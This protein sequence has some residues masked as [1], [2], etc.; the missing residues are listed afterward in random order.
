MF[1][2]PDS[3]FIAFSFTNGPF[4]SGQLKKL[5]ISGGPPT[6]ICDIPAAVPG[7]TWNSDGVIVFAANNAPGLM[8]VS[9][10]GGMATP[11]TSLDRARGETNHRYPR[12]L[13]DGKHFLYQRM[14]NI[15]ENRGIFVGSIDAKPEEQRLEPVMLSDRQAIYTEPLGRGPGRLLFLRDTTLLAQPFDPA[16]FELSGEPVPVADQVASF[17]P[18]T[19]GLFSVSDTG[20]LAYRV[21]VGG[22]QVQLT[23]FDANGKVLGTVGEKGAY[24]N[25][26]LS[27]DGTRIAVTQLDLLTANSDIWVVD[28]ARGNSIKVTFRPGR[29][30]FPV[31]SPDGKR[32][33]FS[34]L[35]AGHLDLYLKNA[36][37]TGEERLI[38]QTE[39]DKRPTSWSK[40]GRFLFFQSNDP[41]AGFDLWVLPAPDGP[42]GATKPVPYLRTERQEFLAT[43]SPDGRWVAYGE[44]EAN[45]TDV[46]VRPFDPNRIAESAAGGK[47]L[48]SKGGAGNPR[49]RGDGMEL[50]YTDTSLATM[51]VDVRTDQTFNPGAPRRLFTLPLA[52]AGDV[53]SDGKRFLNVLN[54][55]AN[56]PAPFTVVTNWQ[57]VLAR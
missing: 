34:S 38:L 29:N 17:A 57:S 23:W 49:W 14:S 24:V 18:A 51:A 33:M 54:E 43:L 39:Q 50:Y 55:G 46:Y 45:N 7:G 10:A 21:G 41:K 20:V 9:A 28:I 25:P 13:P 48:V 30:A 22:N 2:S 3:R 47:W 1:W 37:G 12:F 11:L 5:D 35:N 32:L 40:D 26:A 44:A 42:T 27:P 16:S 56:A 31:W 36:D 15:P 19:V 52:Y 4:T 53:T 8:R 6:T